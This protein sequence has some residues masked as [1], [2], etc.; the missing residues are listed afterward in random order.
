MEPRLELRRRLVENEALGLH[1]G[2]ALLEEVFALPRE[3]QSRMGEHLVE[4]WGTT[5]GQAF[6][7]AH[8]RECEPGVCS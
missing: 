4:T 1:A 8:R 3:Q 7:V 6:P 5:G 2:A